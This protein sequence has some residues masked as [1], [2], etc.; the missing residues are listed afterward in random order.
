MHQDFKCDHYET[1]KTGRTNSQGVLYLADRSLF[2]NQYGE[3][4]VCRVPGYAQFYINQ[5]KQE[6]EYHF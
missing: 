4:K 3:L 2:R 5:Q 1:S 6:K